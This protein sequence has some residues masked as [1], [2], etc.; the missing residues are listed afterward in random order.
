MRSTV[1][2]GLLV[3]SDDPMRGR[4]LWR[5]ANE[6]ERF[7]KASGND[8]WYED[9][10]WY[11]SGLL[12]Q[13][14]VT[15]IKERNKVWYVVTEKGLK[16]YLKRNEPK[17]LRS[18]LQRRISYNV[19]RNIRWHDEEREQLIVELTRE[20]E[21]G[22]EYVRNRYFRELVKAFAYRLEHGYE[23][24][25]EKVVALIHEKIGW[26]DKWEAKLQLEVPKLVQKRRRLSEQQAAGL[27]YETC[28]RCGNWIHRKD[29]VKVAEELAERLGIETGSVCCSCYDKLMGG[30]VD[31]GI[32]A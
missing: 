17:L 23:D 19:E 26:N 32:A 2:L 7:Q 24:M 6:D 12:E 11:M 29:V 9:F 15:K 28:F 4:E 18:H 5:R 3:E 10:P 13:G 21:D 16:R 1:V 30:E 14:V 27:G 22:E 20:L 31:A 25:E 8:F